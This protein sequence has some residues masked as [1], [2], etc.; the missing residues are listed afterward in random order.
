MASSFAIS[1]S[2]KARPLNQPAAGYREVRIGVD[3]VGANRN[4]QRMN[5]TP[6]VEPKSE[7][8]IVCAA[9]TRAG[10]PCKA[11]P[12]TGGDR[13]VFHREKSQ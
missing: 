3:A 7:T 10:L 4:V 8:P 12:V 6:A 1:H 2:A 13:C 11:L 5:P 9:L